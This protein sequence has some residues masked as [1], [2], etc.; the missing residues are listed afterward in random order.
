MFLVKNQRLKHYSN[1]VWDEIKGFE[2][3]AIEAI[4]IELNDKADSLAVSTS[5][6]IPHLDFI[7]RKYL[8]E[9]IYR[10]SVPKNNNS[11]QVFKDDA[12]INVF[13]QSIEKFSTN[14]FEGLESECRKFCPDL[15][16]EKPS[17][18]L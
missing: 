17:N 12:H 1:R 9:I 8:V 5:F 4:P 13:L 6:F 11:W 7:N 3:F 16:N 18:L 14:Y 15:A 2:A 10:P